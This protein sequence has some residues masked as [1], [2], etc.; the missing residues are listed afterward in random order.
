MI[1]RAHTIYAY[2]LQRQTADQQVADTIQ[3]S[4]ATATQYAIHVRVFGAQAIDR[5]SVRPTGKIEVFTDDQLA[6]LLRV[7]FSSTRKGPAGVSPAM[8]AEEVL[9]VIATGRDLDTELPFL[10]EVA[11]KARGRKAAGEVQE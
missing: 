8:A 3:V 1:E 9:S 7:R 10:S 11:P 5:S 6:K 2:T 4:H